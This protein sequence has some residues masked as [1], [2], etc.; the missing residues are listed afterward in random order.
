MV[1]SEAIDVGQVVG[2]Q[3]RVATLVGTDA[4]WVKVAIP[5]SHLKRLAIPGLNADKG[6][7]VEIIHTAENQLQ[8]SKTGTLSGI[9]ESLTARGIWH[10]C[11]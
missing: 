6:G 5:V 2:P 9:L 4:F 7:E 10:R 1:Q 11:L 8:I 3:S